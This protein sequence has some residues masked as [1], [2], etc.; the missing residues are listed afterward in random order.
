MP[1]SIQMTHS[2]TCQEYIC[3]VFHALKTF[4][5]TFLYT[6]ISLFYISLNFLTP[7]HLNSLYKT[8]NV[9]GRNTSNKS[10][11][12]TECL[13]CL[14]CVGKAR[15]QPGVLIC[16]LVL[17]SHTLVIDTPVDSQLNRQTTQLGFTSCL[18]SLLIMWRL[19]LIFYHYLG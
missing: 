11:F 15:I 17:I 1:K 12:H 14:T 16:Y 9:F 10:S 18:R 6:T 7:P 3:A 19:S 5:C 4:N 13:R 2:T 8:Q